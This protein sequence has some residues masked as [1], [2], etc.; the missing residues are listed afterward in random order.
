[1]GFGLNELLGLAPTQKARPLATPKPLPSKNADGGGKGWPQVIAQEATGTKMAP[2]AVAPRQTLNQLS[3]SRERSHK[4]N[5][6]PSTI[7]GISDMRNA[8]PRATSAK[9]KE[10]IIFSSAMLANMP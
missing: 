1:S 7:A 6:K 5:G 3:V 10:S 8:M 4:T 2:M 9:A